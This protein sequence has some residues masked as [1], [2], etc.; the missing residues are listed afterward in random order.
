MLKILSGAQT[1][2]DRAALDAAL[3]KK[4]PCGGWCPEGRKAEDG[5][6][7]ELYPV[8]ELK[9]GGYN[10]RT[11][12][13]VQDSDGTV[14]IYFGQL[15]GGTAETLRY[16]LNEKKPYLLLDGR[17]VN[18]GRAAERIFEFQSLLPDGTLNFAGPRA[19]GEPQA[20]EYTM[21]VVENF[22]ELYDE[23]DF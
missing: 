1:G 7:P 16:C 3:K 17:E 19:S 14:I 9:D 11:K 10:E 22:L 6:V 13:N 15:S 2:V 12:K 8:Q 18:V 4:V 21:K 23:N 5:T 20:Y